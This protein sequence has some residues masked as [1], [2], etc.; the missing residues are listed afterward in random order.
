M[1]IKRVTAVQF[2][3]MN[4]VLTVF[5]N[6]EETFRYRLGNVRNHKNETFS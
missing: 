5:I 3:A 6:A 2:V 4:V 1:S